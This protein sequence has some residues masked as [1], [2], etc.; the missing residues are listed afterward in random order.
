MYIY[1]HVETIFVKRKTEVFA[2][3]LKEIIEEWIQ[4]KFDVFYNEIKNVINYFTNVNNLINNFRHIY[5]II[6]YCLS[7]QKIFKQLQQIGPAAK[8]II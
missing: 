5:G 3:F 1:F 6:N 7:L 8:Y 2:F 4:L